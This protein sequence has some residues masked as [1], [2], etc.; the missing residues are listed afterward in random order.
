MPK[1]ATSGLSAED[2]VTAVRVHADRVHDAVRRQGAS[3]Q[4]AIVILETS[5]IEAVQRARSFADLDSLIGW[6]FARA[7]ALGLQEPSSGGALP[8]GG[9]LLA[10]DQ[11]QQRL[12]EALERRPER[13]RTALLLRDAYDLPAAVV[14]AALGLDPDSAMVLVGKARLHLLPD[15]YDTTVP[16][17][18]GHPVDEAA[19]ARLAEGGPIMARD[20]T[21]KRHAQ[22]CAGCRPVVEA[23]DDARR[24]LAALSVVA[25]PDADREHLLGLVERRAEAVLPDQLEIARLEALLAEADDDPLPRRLFAPIPILS[26]LV[27]ATL[28]GLAIGNLIA[29]DN[30]GVFVARQNLPAI[31]APPPL[32]ITV[33][34]VVVSDPVPSPRIFTVAPTTPPP[35]TPPPTTASAGPAS[36]AISAATGANGTVVTVTGSGWTDSVPVALD[37]RTVG[38]TSTGSQVF[39]TPAADGTFSTQLALNDP[40]GTVGPHAIVATDGVKT[41]TAAFTAT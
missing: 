26:A 34:R 35:T 38:G 40:S 5:A 12:A 23:Q 20:A 18:S 11:Q 2:V 33:P 1:I 28:A 27:L 3:E 31:T 9:G 41:D 22:T 14:A 29:D 21:T 32:A 4:S 30:T 17:L 25:L 15:V 19:L 16:S 37:Y 8:L 24:L 39:V 7:R 10:D 13:E 6:W 36:I